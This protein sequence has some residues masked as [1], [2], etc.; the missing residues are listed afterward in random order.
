MTSTARARRLPAI[1]APIASRQN[2]HAK[3]IRSLW[4]RKERERTG[5]CFVEGVRLVA[6]A[7]GSDTE[8]ESLIVAPDLLASELGWQLA[9]QQRRAGVPYR[10]CSA[11]AFRSISLRESPQGIG[12]VVRQ[13]WTTLAQFQPADGPGW[14]ALDGV[15][16]PGNLGTILR[17]CDAAGSAGVILLG[18]TADPYDPVAVRASMG[19]GFALRLARASFAELLEW[20]HQQG[21]AL[22]GTS[23]SAPMDYR[24]AVY[25]PPVVLLMGNERSGLSAEQQAQCDLMVRIPMAGR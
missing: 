15:R 4:Q 17:T 9:I 8:I 24:A 2:P 25:R 11:E 13:R 1:S 22:V 19:A 20:Q 23:G 10:E 5:L 18:H 6:E 14:V 16:D 12:A 3:F 7:A 21:Y